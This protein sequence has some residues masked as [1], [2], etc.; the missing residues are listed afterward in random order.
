[1]NLKGIEWVILGEI[2]HPNRVLIYDL[3]FLDGFW[4]YFYLQVNQWELK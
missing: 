2:P 4:R 3:A 1:M